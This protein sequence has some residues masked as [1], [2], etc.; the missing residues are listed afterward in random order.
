[1]FGDSEISFDVEEQLRTHLP[2]GMRYTSAL[3]GLAKVV[4]TCFA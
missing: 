2:S 3:E 4:E 1:V